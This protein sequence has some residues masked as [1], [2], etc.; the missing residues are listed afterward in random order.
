MIATAASG[1]GATI[2]LAF[3]L[4][5]A[6]RA[7]IKTMLRRISAKLMELPGA[8]P[9][10][11]DG[12]SRR[13]VTDTR[14]GQQIE[15]L[16]FTCNVCGTRVSHWPL[17]AIDRD[18]ASCAGC[19]SS[20]RFRS[21]VHLLSL[22]L[23]G[24]SIA[25]P[26]WPVRR[27]KSGLGLSDSATYGQRLEVKTGYTN[28]F[29]HKAPQLDICNP[30]PTRAG[31]CDFLIATE[32][33]EHVPP[34][35]SRAFAGAFK[36]LKPGGLLIMSVPFSLQPE[37]LEHFP[38]LHD[39]KLERRNGEWVLINTRRDGVIEEHTGLVFHG[40]P[41]STL[42]MRLFSKA[43]LLRA[44]SEAGFTDVKVHDEPVLE[45]G[46]I[47]WEAWSLPITARKPAA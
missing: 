45:W 25:L 38:D 39:F 14:T 17:A 13:P 37:T 10:I 7:A 3:G 9:Q 27:D 44:L 4:D 15:T 23:H 36:L 8:R 31:T 21:I 40:G 42:E 11:A 26:R 30:D 5:A 47:N 12:V 1:M 29:F 20:V 16:N 35:A 32:V 6:H 24:K 41:G 2:L 43:G 33:F 19:A 46:I 34:P 22:E 18:V 28:T